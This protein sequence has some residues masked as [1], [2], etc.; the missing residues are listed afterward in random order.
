M[1]DPKSF[2]SKLSYSLRT[3]LAVAEDATFVGICDLPYWLVMGGCLLRRGG[4]GLYDKTVVRVALPRLN[5]DPSLNSGVFP[6]TGTSLEVSAIL[7]SSQVCRS[8][9]FPSTSHSN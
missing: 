6:F 5:S 7:G 9:I 1:Q 3:D 8:S 4:A 2:M